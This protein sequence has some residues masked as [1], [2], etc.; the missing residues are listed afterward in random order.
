M[1][2]VRVMRV[3]MHQ[4]LVSMRMRV[5]LS[6]W[7]IRRV[8]V[9]MVLVVAVE[10]FVLQRLVPMFVLMPLRQM[11]PDAESHQ[12]PA[13]Q[14]PPRNRL[15]K[16]GDGDYRADEWSRREIGRGARGPEV[17]QRE[18]KEHQTQSIT[19]KPNQ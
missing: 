4:R 8:Q 2:N 14:E 10:M 19:E 3:D 12:C 18:D 5:R 11:E 7:V 1:V 13:Q 17:S 16:D 9:P 15:V 6:R